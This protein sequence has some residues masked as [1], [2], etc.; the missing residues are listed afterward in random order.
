MLE[1]QR[2]NEGL[3]ST[4]CQALAAKIMIS[5]A[6]QVSKGP[7]PGLQSSWE[8]EMESWG[9]TTWTALCSESRSIYSLEIKGL[10]STSHFML[11]GG[12][13]A[14]RGSRP[15]LSFLCLGPRR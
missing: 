15:G 12:V 13:G 7:G 5:E 10:Q 6:S 14:G 1:L 9:L 3:F 11:P 4:A 8:G 2:R